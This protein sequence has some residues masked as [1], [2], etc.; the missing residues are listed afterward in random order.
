MKN[1]LVYKVVRDACNRKVVKGFL[2]NPGISRRFCIKLGTMSEASVQNDIGYLATK[3]RIIG[4]FLSL[5]EKDE[6]T[7][8]EY[9]E[10]HK[11]GEVLYSTARKLE[12]C[13]RN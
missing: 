1:L 10:C 8:S 3:V 11:I 6:L 5:M 9:N 13:R 2:W 7:G 4:E 12:N